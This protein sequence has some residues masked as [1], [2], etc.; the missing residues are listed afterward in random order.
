MVILKYEGYAVINKY[1][2]G[3]V[4]GVFLLTGCEQ[5]EPAKEI[6]REYRQYE[7]LYLDPPKHVYIDI[8]DVKT[9]VVWKRLFVSKHCNQ[10]RNIPTGSI[11]GFELVTYQ[12]KD[13]SV[14]QK[15]ENY[16]DICR[17]SENGVS[18]VKY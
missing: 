10:W 9:G 5:Q 6:S 14:Y 3:L 7:L 16:H 8:K 12:N 13:G 2:V 18:F 17:R 4:V 1:L 15:V 11:W